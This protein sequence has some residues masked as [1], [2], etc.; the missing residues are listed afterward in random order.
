MLLMPSLV[1]AQGTVA[2][3]FDGTCTD[4]EDG[5]ISASI[6]WTSNIDGQVG[7]GAQGTMQLT[8]GDHTITAVC[9][10]SGGLQATAAVNIRVDVND[11]PAV[12]ITLPVDGSTHSG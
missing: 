3:P 4:P 5:D 6:V 11:P 10:D 2:V 12:N 1:L 9:T 8:E 7:T